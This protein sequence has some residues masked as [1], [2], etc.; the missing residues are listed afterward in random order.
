MSRKDGS[1][2]SS[3]IFVKGI[4]EM[5]G[6]TDFDAAATGFDYEVEYPD[7]VDN[8]GPVV[9]APIA[10]ELDDDRPAELRIADL[11]DSLP[12]C[13]GVLLG[14]V[15]AC[16]EQ[17]LEQDV[18]DIVDGL[19]EAH[20]S[21]YSGFAFCR[22][23]EKAG[24]LEHVR[25]NGDPYHEES[26]QPITIVEDGVEYIQ[27]AEPPASFWRSTADGLAFAEADDPGKRAQDVVRGDEAYASIYKFILEECS[28]GSASGKDLS[29]VIDAHPLT[30]EPRLFA[31]HFIKK[32]EDVGVIEWNGTWSVP[33]KAAVSLGWLDD[34]QPLDR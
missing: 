19:Q 29:A 9:L 6:Y 11:F 22:M 4:T 13:R 27:A 31:M 3:R 32:L 20:H 24:A 1:P 23:L 16:R 25:E 14:I 10:E 33:D 8:D 15:E 28:Q 26:L 12:G 30:Q 18:V 34:I 17:R 5:T 21:V 2:G 7:I